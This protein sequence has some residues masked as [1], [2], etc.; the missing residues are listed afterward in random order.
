MASS[1]L[2]LQTPL[3]TC[4]SC[5][6]TFP[7][8]PNP[9]METMNDYL[10]HNP[11]RHPTYKELIG[12]KHC[13]DSAKQEIVAYTE[14]I[15]RIGKLMQELQTR[16]GLLMRATTRIDELL[17]PSVFR[18]PVEI[19]LAIF[20]IYLE[21]AGRNEGKS[22]VHPALTLG[23]VCSQWRDVTY[24]SPALWT[25]IYAEEIQSYDST[26]SHRFARLCLDNS[27][28]LPLQISFQSYNPEM[29]HAF[30]EVVKN[31]R[32]WKDVVVDC[33][34]GYSDFPTDVP[35]LQTLTLTG[36]SHRK[37]PTVNVFS[38]ALQNLRLHDEMGGSIRFDTR[39][40]THL[41]LENVVDFFA[42]VEMLERSPALTTLEVERMSFRSSKTLNPPL[43]LRQ[44]TSLAIRD[45]GTCINPVCAFFNN[46]QVP[47]L[48]DLTISGRSDCSLGLFD[49]QIISSRAF[50]IS[51][52][53]LI[54]LTLNCLLFDR[55]RDLIDTLTPFNNTLT[56][57]SLVMCHLGCRGEWDDFL[58]RMTF[59][60]STRLLENLKE[61]EFGYGAWTRDYPSLFCD[62][63]ESRWQVDD[64]VMRLSRLC[65]LC[66]FENEKLDVDGRLSELDGQGLEVN[67]RVESLEC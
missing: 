33:F 23:R 45:L 52:P 17:R 61:L 9:S 31:C 29:C 47:Q 14:E 18:L 49:T 53:P 20:H 37:L 6:Y 3:K 46:V 10:T 25:K 2:D 40:L 4:D 62:M 50:S 22:C 44:L 11:N 54:S 55:A 63:I 56:R 66:S 12:L 27:G 28:E 34:S 16:R 21:D 36:T 19:L 32:R 13:L 5:H 48:A 1:L 65:V 24:S 57:L 8:K 43:P 30:L 35:L 59:P 67:V 51:P 64:E 58:R 60:Q 7:T 15:Q 26:S 41:S 42:F 38:P 39:S